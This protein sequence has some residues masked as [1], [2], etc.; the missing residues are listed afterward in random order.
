MKANEV[1]TTDNNP[2]HNQ[3]EAESH[4]RSAFHWPCNASHNAIPTLAANNSTALKFTGSC[5]LTNTP[6]RVLKMAARIALVSPR[7]MPQIWSFS[8]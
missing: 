8:A 2:I 7:V 4:T 5:D 1:A 6:F 3:S